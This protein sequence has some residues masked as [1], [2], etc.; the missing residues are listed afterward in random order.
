MYL[1]YMTARQNI[2]PERRSALYAVRQKPINEKEEERR[3]QPPVP[4]RCLEV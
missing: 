1:S 4:L 3:A 2:H